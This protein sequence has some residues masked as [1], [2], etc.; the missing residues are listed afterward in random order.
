MNP[1]WYYNAK[2]NPTVQFMVGQQDVYRH[3]ERSRRRGARAVAE[4]DDS[5]LSALRRLRKEGGAAHNS[6]GRAEA[7][8]GNRVAFRFLVN[9][10]FNGKPR[11]TFP[12]AHR[13]SLE[14]RTRR[15]SPPWRRCAW[16]NPADW[17]GI[18]RRQ[19]VGQA[20]PQ[21]AAFAG[22]HQQ[23]ARAARALTGHKAK[24]GRSAAILRKPVQIDRSVDFQPATL[25]ALFAAA[26]LR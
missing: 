2:A 25:H 1:G 7:D 4:E 24:Q 10:R 21:H 22:D 17:R 13:A 15:P 8:A 16:A 6:G 3:G 11:H 12:N 5:D 18:R 20:L 14:R 26:I 23:Q 19:P 9:A